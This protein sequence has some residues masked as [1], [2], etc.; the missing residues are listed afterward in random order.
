MKVVSGGSY[1]KNGIGF[2]FSF[3]RQ[4]HLVYFGFSFKGEFDILIGHLYHRFLLLIISVIPIQCR[5]R[6]HL[7]GHGSDWPGSFL[8]CQ[9]RSCS[10]S[11]NR[12]EEQNLRFSQL[13]CEELGFLARQSN[14]QQR[15]SAMERPSIWRGKNLEEGVRRLRSSVGLSLACPSSG[16]LLHDNGVWQTTLPWVSS[17]VQTA[18]CTLCH[19]RDPWQGLQ[20]VLSQF[21]FVRCF[22]SDLGCFCDN[23]AI[24]S[25]MAN[26]SRSTAI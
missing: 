11:V 5:S 25:V 22:I 4:G 26:D 23:Q 21:K 9:L 19:V 14:E 3:G 12:Q 2:V 8:V 16:Q 10:L 7:L 17:K 1:T 24:G 18:G 15:L 6:Q 13:V 20:R